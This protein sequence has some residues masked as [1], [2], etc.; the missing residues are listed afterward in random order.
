M[1]E[2]AFASSIFS[3]PYGCFCLH[4]DLR[5]HIFLTLQ[6]KKLSQ[7][8]PVA[9]TGEPLVSQKQDAV[10]CPPGLQS[11]SPLLTSDP[12]LQHFNTSQRQA[13]SRKLL[14]PPQQVSTAEASSLG[15]LASAV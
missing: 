13:A 4:N 14:V 5:K 11:V 12:F 10:G 7:E 6:M 9:T 15:S 8:Y 1:G 2:G 3:T